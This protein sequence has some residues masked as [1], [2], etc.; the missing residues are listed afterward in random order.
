MHDN[1]SEGVN[2]VSA[3]GT[4]IHRTFSLISWEIASDRTPYLRIDCDLGRVAM[5]L[6]IDRILF[7]DLLPALKNNQGGGGVLLSLEFHIWHY[8][9]K[10]WKHWL[11]LFLSFDWALFCLILPLFHKFSVRGT[12][13]PLRNSRLHVTI[14]GKWKR[15]WMNAGIVR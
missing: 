1:T 4:V 14:Q 15:T 8:L 6:L 5:L 12:I 10:V 3:N 13:A 2:K 11:L 9:I 7:V